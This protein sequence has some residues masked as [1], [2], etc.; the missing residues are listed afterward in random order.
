[1]LVHAARL[2]IER[3][4][5]EEIAGEHALGDRALLAVLLFRHLLGRDHAPADIVLHAFDLDARLDRLEGL[6]L[7]AR[8]RVKDKPLLFHRRPLSP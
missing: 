1:M 6:R 4:L 5:A 2:V 3:E 8:E 7:L